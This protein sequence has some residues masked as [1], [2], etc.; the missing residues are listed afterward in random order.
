MILEFQRQ[1]EANIL[2][3]VI[4]VPRLTKRQQNSIMIITGDVIDKFLKMR[5]E[6]GWY[7][8]RVIQYSCVDRRHRHKV[9]FEDG[10]CLKVD[11]GAIAD[12]GNLMWL[13]PDEPRQY[14]AFHGKEMQG[15][16][17]RYKPTVNHD[18][19]WVYA[20]IAAAVEWQRFLLVSDDD[21]PWLHALNINAAFRNIFMRAYQLQVQA[22][23]WLAATQ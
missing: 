18:C 6:C 3:E 9:W 8:G 15:C 13:S 22:P 12:A 17:V 14:M 4:F 7:V 23:T 11:L 19:E 2:I 20:K 10:D 21:E 1:E 5:F 16:V